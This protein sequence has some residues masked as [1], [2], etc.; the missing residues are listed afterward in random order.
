MF[1]GYTR[2]TELSVPCRS[3][4]LGC[5]NRCYV[6]CEYGLAID[7]RLFN[8]HQDGTPTSQLHSLYMKEMGKLLDHAIECHGLPDNRSKTTHTGNGAYQG[9]FAFTL[10]KSPDD[11]LTELDMI[12]AVRKIMSQKSCPVKKYA[13]YLEYG[14]PELKLHPHIHGL[15]ETESSGRI[16]AKHWKRSWKIWDEKHKLGRGFRGGY[17]RPVRSEEGY[18]DYIK[19]D[20][21]LNESFGLEKESPA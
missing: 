14:D 2:G 15:Y 9:A 5:N 16:E 4:D 18:S 21:G 17:H 11:D 3:T 6:H 13:W 10:T 20:K 7:R 1:C 12:K 19:K 8:S